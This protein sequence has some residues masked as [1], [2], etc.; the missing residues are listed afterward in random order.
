MS[1]GPFLYVKD[2]YISGYYQCR[3]KT[4]INPSDDD[5]ATEVNDIIIK[6]VDRRFSDF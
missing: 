5:N 3:I 1:V 4:K 2:G 6:E